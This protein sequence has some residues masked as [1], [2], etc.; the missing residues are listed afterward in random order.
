MKYDLVSPKK[1]IIGKSSIKGRGVFA[2]S[3]IEEG[4]IVEECHFIIPEK[5]KGG[6]DN[7][8]RRYMFGRLCVNTKEEYEK[9]SSKL[10]LHQLVD[11]EDLK[12][13]LLESLKDLGYENLESLFSHA[14][15]LGL[16]MVYNHSDNPNIMYEFD[17]DSMLF[18]YTASEEIEEGKELFINYGNT[19]LRK[20]IN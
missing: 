2:K 7:E 17:Y 18:R 13:E 3:K 9:L 5:D 19:E 4:E 10:F 8:M 15:V 14:F 11:D 1:L 12:E 20:D 6:E 16:G